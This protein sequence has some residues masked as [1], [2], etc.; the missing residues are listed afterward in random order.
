LLAEHKQTRIWVSTTSHE[1]DDKKQTVFKSY[2][3]MK[4]LQ[5]T[6]SIATIVSMVAEKCTIHPKL[7]LLTIPSLIDVCGSNC[8]TYLKL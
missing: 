5:H 6:Q 1:E 4:N 7:S 2:K 3:Q 8:R